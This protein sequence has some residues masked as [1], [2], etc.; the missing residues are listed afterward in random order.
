V[1]GGKRVLV[2]EDEPLIGLDLEAAIVE[3]GGVIVAV[4]TNLQDAMKFADDATVDGA[5]LDLRLGSET[6]EGLLR[7]LRQRG[8]ACV[9]HTGQS[10]RDL[11]QFSP[12]LRIIDKPA[13]PE[14]V[15]S[16]LAAEISE[17]S[18]R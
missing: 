12:E 8:V 14:F 15:I 5:I 2:V 9:V 13:L 7:M 16:S 18:K 10:N 3:A 11:T 1:L 4:A 17:Q 6:T